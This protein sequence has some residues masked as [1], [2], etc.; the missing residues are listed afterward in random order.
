[1]SKHSC[2]DWSPTSNTSIYSRRYVSVTA[3]VFKLSE[4][5]SDFSNI[6]SLHWWESVLWTKRVAIYQQGE[7]VGTVLIGRYTL[8]FRSLCLWLW[9]YKFNELCVLQCYVCNG[10]C[11]INVE[12]PDRNYLQLECTKNLCKKTKQKNHWL[13]NSS[14]GLMMALYVFRPKVCELWF[15]SLLVSFCMVLDYPN[16]QASVQILFHSCGEKSAIKYGSSV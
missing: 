5:L 7:S 16:F 8:S 11:G 10:S 13:R 9:S 12:H 2:C 4:K 6:Y 15:F 1:M 14:L 3:F